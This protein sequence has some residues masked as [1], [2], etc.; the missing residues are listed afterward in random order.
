MGKYFKYAI[1]EI[2]LV[3]IGILIALQ[4]NNWNEQRKKEQ[5]TAY[6]LNALTQ[7]LKENLEV[8]TTTNIN[9]NKDLNTTGNLRQRLRQKHATIDTLK[10]I[11]LNE[12]NLFVYSF[13]KLNDNTY[14]TLQNTGHI[15]YLD[16]WL[17]EYLQQLDFIHNNLYEA[18]KSMGEDYSVTVI[19]F[20]RLFP[21][22]TLN[23]ALSKK[24]DD[25]YTDAERIS[26]LTSITGTKNGMYHSI[27][28]RS[29]PLEEKTRKL[30]DTLTTLYKR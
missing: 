10:Q 16:T 19:E 23:E 5:K 7:E 22:N 17:Q 25:E 12:F 26:A 21:N 29:K 3:V 2:L 30:V 27:L 11:A 20:L 1:G 18:D 13:S 9:I 14:R 6:Y 24:V 8:I 28:R 15:E 4:I